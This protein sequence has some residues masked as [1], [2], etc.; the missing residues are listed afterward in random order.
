[1][2]YRHCP[3]TLPAGHRATEARNRRLWITANPVDSRTENVRGV[4]YGMPARRPCPVGATLAGRSQAKLAALRDTLAAD[5]PRCADLPLLPA[6][7]TDPGSLREIAG[8]ARVVATTVGPYLSHGEPLVAACASAG[9]DYVDLTGEPEF[10]DLM[11]LRHHAR[12]V[13]TGA[14]LVHCCGF[15]AVPHDLGT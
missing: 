6:D 4:W 13:E 8:A 12:A 15:D 11:Y 1:M 9:T 2:P 7:V 10:V 14:R 5:Q 3:I